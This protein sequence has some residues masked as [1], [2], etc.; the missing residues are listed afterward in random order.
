MLHCSCPG[1]RGSHH[2]IIWWI[3][4]MKV[5]FLWSNWW[6]FYFAVWR[7]SLGLSFVGT[8]THQLLSHLWCCLYAM[9]LFLEVSGVPLLNTPITFAIRKPRK[10]IEILFFCICICICSSVTCLTSPGFRVSSRS[11]WLVLWL[12]MSYK[13]SLENFLLR[14]GNHFFHGVLQ[15]VPIHLWIGWSQGAEKARLETWEP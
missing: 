7:C 13:L 15:K 9:L 1:T 11:L 14:E 12:A 10:G 6:S 5:N 3:C 8:C 4:S 2:V